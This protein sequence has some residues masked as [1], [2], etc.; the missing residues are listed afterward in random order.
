MKNIYISK[1]EL[2]NKAP[3]DFSAFAESDD[4]YASGVISI[5]QS[6]KDEHGAQVTDSITFS[7]DEAD[8]IIEAIRNAKKALIKHR[9]YNCLLSE[10]KKHHLENPSCVTDFGSYF[11]P[12]EAKPKSN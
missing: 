7:E 10:I 8:A 12:P 3:A 5:S 1:L 2:K 11:R 4:Y 9:D 6:Q